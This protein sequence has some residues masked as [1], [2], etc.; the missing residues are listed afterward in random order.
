[1]YRLLFEMISGMNRV[2]QPFL[3]PNIAPRFT[4]LVPLTLW[5]FLQSIDDLQANTFYQ[6]LVKCSG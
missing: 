2:T 6:F 3:W 5:P 1:M 4:T